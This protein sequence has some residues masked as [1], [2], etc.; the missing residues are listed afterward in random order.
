MTAGRQKVLQSAVG[1][2][3]AFRGADDGV[4][5][6]CQVTGELHHTGFEMSVPPLGGARRVPRRCQPP[7]LPCGAGRRAE[8]HVRR[9][10]SK[11]APQLLF[12]VNL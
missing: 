10:F 5:P 9:V 3:V 12:P 2:I 7:P 8:A 1:E 6:L 4:F 11:L